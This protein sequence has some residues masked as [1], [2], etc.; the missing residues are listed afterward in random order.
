MYMELRFDA[1]QEYQIRAI[2]SVSGL[3]EGQSKIES[4]LNYSQKSGFLASPN[5]LDL[6]ENT[7]L[8]NL[9][10]IQNTNGISCS[11]NLEYI[12]KDIDTPDGLHTV[13]FPNFSI[14]MET[15]TGK[16]Y[17]YIRTIIELN[18]QYGFRRFISSPFNCH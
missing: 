2:E 11:M 15:G 18:K 1:R 6:D 8:E 5:R 17:V 3:F 10:N 7:I 4:T 9:K 12:K 14:E 16:T 13:C